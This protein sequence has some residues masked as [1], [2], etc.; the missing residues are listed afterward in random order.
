MHVCTCDKA[1]WNNSVQRKNGCFPYPVHVGDFSGHILGITNL[2]Y[3]CNC[4]KVL[5]VHELPQCEPA[6]HVNC[7]YFCHLKCVIIKVDWVQLKIHLHVLLYVCAL[8]SRF[9]L[10]Y[11]TGETPCIVQGG[12]KCSIWWW[13]YCP[14]WGVKYKLTIVIH[15]DVHVLLYCIV[16]EKMPSQY[17]L[18]LP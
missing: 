14:R 5:W 11:Y 7:A 10:E 17:E 3:D 12:K 6:V 9:W 8:W 16:V 18:Y 2:S 1:S 4:G 13:G 15:N